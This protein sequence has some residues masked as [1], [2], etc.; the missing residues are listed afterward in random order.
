MLKLNHRADFDDRGGARPGL[1]PLSH[2]HY[3]KLFVS[4][5][6]YRHVF[7]YFN[8]IKNMLMD[9]KTKSGVSSANLVFYEEIS[10]IRHIE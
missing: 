7:E 8:I 1:K 6:R 4:G 5:Q 9:Q 3:G 10:I 2:G